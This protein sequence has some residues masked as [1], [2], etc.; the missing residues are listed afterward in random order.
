MSGRPL[1][2]FVA[3]QAAA[4]LPELSAGDRAKLLAGLE[5]LMPARDIEQCQIL[6]AALNEADEAKRRADE[7]QLLFREVLNIVPE[8]PQ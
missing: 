4:R 1:I 3:T 2:D 8:Q 5:L 6:V 7:A